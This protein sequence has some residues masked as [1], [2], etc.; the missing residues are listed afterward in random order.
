AVPASCEIAVLNGPVPRSAVEFVFH[1]LVPVLNEPGQIAD[2]GEI[3]RQHGPRPAMLHVDNGMARLRLTAR[4][5]SRLVDEFSQEGA[6]KWCGLI[7]HL[8]CADHPAHAFNDL[9]RT[10]FAAMRRIFSGVPASLAASS[11]IFLGRE[12][13]FDFVRPGAAL[14]GINPQPGTS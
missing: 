14:Y 10:R 8:A 4:E 3:V 11:G 5:I 1:R 7:S 12:F 6:A 13:R 9:Q 2:W